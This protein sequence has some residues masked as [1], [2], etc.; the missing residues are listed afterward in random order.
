MRWR[1]ARKALRRANFVVG[2][3]RPPHRALLAA[4]SRIR[5]KDFGFI[6]QRP[7]T[8]KPLARGWAVEWLSDSVM[9]EH[10]E[11]ADLAAAVAFVCQQGPLDD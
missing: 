10:R 11:F 3:R 8:I 4:K 5:T 9:V 7:Y 2:E 1:D 6:Y